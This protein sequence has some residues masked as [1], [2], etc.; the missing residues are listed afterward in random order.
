MYSSLDL[1]RRNEGGEHTMIWLGYGLMWLSVSA[2]VSVG[3]YVTHSAWCLW[4]FLLPALMKM[5][6]GDKKGG[7]EVEIQEETSG[8]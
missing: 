3:L 7:E 1:R 2:A 6:S 4:A 8:D 5:S